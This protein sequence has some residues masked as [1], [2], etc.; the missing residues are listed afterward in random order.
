MINWQAVKIGVKDAHPKGR[1]SDEEYLKRYGH[2]R[3]EQ[4][5]SQEKQ[6]SSENSSENQTKKYSPFFNQLNFDEQQECKNI[7]ER[8]LGYFSLNWARMNYYGITMDDINHAMT[9]DVF[10]TFMDVPIGEDGLDLLNYPEKS[11]EDNV[12][13]WLTDFT[14]N[15]TMMI[16][17]YKDRY[18][19]E[20]KPKLQRLIK[21]SPVVAGALWRGEGFG[22]G[23]LTEGMSINFECQSCAN[24]GSGYSVASNFIQDEYE[25]GGNVR[26]F[27]FPKGV[28]GLNIQSCSAYPNQHEYLIDGDFIIDSIE[29]DEYEREIITL[30]F[31]DNSNG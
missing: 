11:K 30:K 28:R 20:I 17:K 24:D 4:E 29:R 26:L 6:T 18:N 1:L 2:P 21:A 23:E 12:Y 10:F 15:R 5:P 14:I 13:A 7:N 31:K 3:R 25:N 19:A 9:D 22:R 27:K 8:C 16:D